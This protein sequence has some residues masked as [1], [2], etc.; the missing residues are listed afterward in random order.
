MQQKALK[1]LSIHLKTH[2]YKLKKLKNMSDSVKKWHEI[3]KENPEEVLF[4]PEEKRESE[5]LDL[6]AL[7]V[8]SGKIAQVTERAAQVQKEYYGASLLVGLQI[9]CDE[10]NILQN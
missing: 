6:I 3:Q 1:S 7:A 2:F 9:A 10:E 4:C 5:I 8:K